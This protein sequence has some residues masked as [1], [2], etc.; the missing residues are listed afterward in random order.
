MTVCRVYVIAEV[1]VN[2]NGNPQTALQLVDEAA[3]CGADA[4]KFQSFSADE[5]VTRTADKAPYQRER[6]SADQTQHAMLMQLELDRETHFALKRRCDAHGL[7]FLSTAFDENSLEMLIALGMKRIK[8]PSGDITNL[9]LL[10][11]VS[12]YGLPVILSTGMANLDEVRSAV[13]LL[14]RGGLPKHMITLL[15]CTSE[16][17]API[18]DVNL[19]AI[20]TL[21]NEFEVAVGYSDHT[22]GAEIAIAAVGMGATV[23]EKHITLDR[24]AQGPDHAASMEPRAFS[25]MVQAIRRVENALG[26]GLKVPKGSEIRNRLIARR[27]IVAARDIAPGETFTS[28]NVTVKRPGT[29]TSPMLWDEVIGSVARRRFNMDEV[30]EL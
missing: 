18:H 7:E 29:G 25:Q 17:P 21:R 12:S 27:S 13:S 10:R 22:L 16:Y 5:L 28:E 30:I 6:T 11:R 3:K 4:V 26:D 8:I 20:Q 19:R 9:P 1:G 14:T 24:T 2:H 23:L 15:H